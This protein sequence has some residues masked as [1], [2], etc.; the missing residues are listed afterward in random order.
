V[1]LN[2]RGNRCRGEHF[3]KTKEG[4][5]DHAE[6]LGDFSP[7]GVKERSCGVQRSAGGYKVVGQ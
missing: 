3:F 6:D 7:A 4:E 2:K 1:V 5:A